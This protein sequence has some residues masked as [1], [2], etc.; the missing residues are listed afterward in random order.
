MPRERLND[1][2]AEIRFWAT[3][4]TVAGWFPGDHGDAVA[5]RFCRRL[6]GDLAVGGMVPHALLVDAGHDLCQRRLSGAVLDQTMISFGEDRTSRCSKPRTPDI[7][8]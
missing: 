3:V 7:P 4:M 8:S 6:E 5:Q 2:V 1:F